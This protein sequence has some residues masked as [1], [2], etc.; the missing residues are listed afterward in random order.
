MSS[1][2]LP[3][4]T[5]NSSVDREGEA[6]E[7]RGIPGLVT[8][9]WNSPWLFAAIISGLCCCCLLGCCCCRRKERDEAFDKLEEKHP[10]NYQREAST[11]KA[12]ASLKVSGTLPLGGL[13]KEEDV[14]VEMACHPP[15]MEP[16]ELQNLGL[17][18][19]IKVVSVVSADFAAKDATFE[20]D[21]GDEI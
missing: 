12:K 11:D 15:Q 19:A 7:A 21:T 18:P 20:C 8:L 17:M 2:S 5:S 14:T 4:T 6:G 10:P 9:T 3:T 1:I 16:P 13:A